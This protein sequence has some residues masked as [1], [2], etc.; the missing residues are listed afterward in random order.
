[1]CDFI[2]E[3][4]IGQSTNQKNQDMIL[5]NGPQVV[6]KEIF[7]TLKSI[8]PKREELIL[9]IQNLSFIKYM[10]KKICFKSNS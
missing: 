5:M 9:A 10:M 8:Y 3:N 1:M 4:Q 2:F 7:K 6:V